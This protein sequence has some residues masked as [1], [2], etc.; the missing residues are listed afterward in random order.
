MQSARPLFPVLAAT[1]QKILMDV[2]CRAYDSMQ[3]YDRRAGDVA[4]V[5]GDN[6]R[7]SM[8]VLY[9]C[10]VTRILK[11]SRYVGVHVHLHIEQGFKDSDKF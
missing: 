4:I 5:G 8:Y 7:N 11:I 2:E 6:I 10:M 1:S 3:P 9:V